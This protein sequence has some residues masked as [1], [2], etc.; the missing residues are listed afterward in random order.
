MEV[1]SLLCLLIVCNS[2]AVLP[3]N[4]LHTRSG[5]SRKYNLKR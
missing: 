1:T 4:I 2:L 3:L 5:Y